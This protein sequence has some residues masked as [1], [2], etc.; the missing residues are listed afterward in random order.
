[1]SLL[2]QTEGLVE[3]VVMRDHQPASSP[4]SE[5]LATPDEADPVDLPPLPSSPLPVE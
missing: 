4:D 5:P 1:M 3:L 2:K